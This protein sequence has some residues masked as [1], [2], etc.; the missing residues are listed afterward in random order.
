VVINN[1][2][3]CTVLISLLNSLTPVNLLHRICNLQ[4]YYVL[5]RQN[6]KL[7][8]YLPEH[9]AGAP[10]FFLSEDHQMYKLGLMNELATVR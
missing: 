1:T 6:P 5:Y 7:S 10:G 8:L 9:S 3:G 4:T 2:L